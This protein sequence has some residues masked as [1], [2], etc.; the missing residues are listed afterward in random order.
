MTCLLHCL[1]MYWWLHNNNYMNLFSFL[2]SYSW[3]TGYSNGDAACATSKRGSRWRYGDRFDAKHDLESMDAT[4]APAPDPSEA[5]SGNQEE[6][7]EEPETSVSWGQSTRQGDQASQRVLDRRT[8]GGGDW[9]THQEWGPLWQ[10]EGALAA[11]TQE[12]RTV[13]RARS[14]FVRRLEG[15]LH[16]VWNTGGVWVVLNPSPTNLA[17]DPSKTRGKRLTLTFGSGGS[18]F[19]HTSTPSHRSL[20]SV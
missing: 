19:A 17:S 20:S 13:A 11:A 18:S 8:K 14:C 4:D 1:L 15:H 16:V 3:N 7:E 9:I 12:D 5:G 10:K 6:E 2:Y